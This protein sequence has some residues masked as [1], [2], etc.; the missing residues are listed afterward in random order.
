MSLLWVLVVAAAMLLEG[1]A[2]GAHNGATLSI[3]IRE[4]LRRPLARFV[5]YPLWA[6]LTWHWFLAGHGQSPTWRDGVAL[7][8]GVCVASMQLLMGR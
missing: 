7:G 8:I 6:W 1:Y 4:Q 3:L 5:Y 2:L